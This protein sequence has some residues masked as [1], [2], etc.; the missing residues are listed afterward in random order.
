MNGDFLVGKNH[1]MPELVS[2]KQ[3]ADALKLQSK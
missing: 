3:D 1:T 2:V